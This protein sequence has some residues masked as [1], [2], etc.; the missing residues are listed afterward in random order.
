MNATST[1]SF[2]YLLVA[3]TAMPDTMYCSGMPSGLGLSGCSQASVQSLRSIRAGL[4][5]NERL[6]TVSR[7]PALM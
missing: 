3:R 5:V 4:P 2:G 7:L 1:D 6:R